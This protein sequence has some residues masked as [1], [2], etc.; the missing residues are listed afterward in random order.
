MSATTISTYEDYLKL[1]PIIAWESSL[2]PRDGST[3][4]IGN[5]EYMMYSPVESIL[6]E[7]RKN[8]PSDKDF[9]KFL[10]T[11]LEVAKE[12]DGTY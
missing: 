6:L 9:E 4:T 7:M 1:H 8:F 5:N 11:C 2:P 3:C 10:R 12:M